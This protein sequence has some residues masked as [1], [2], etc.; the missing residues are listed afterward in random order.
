MIEKLNIDCYR[1]D[2]NFQPLEYWRNNDASDRRGITE[3]KHINGLYKL[4]D[5]L[6]DKFPNLLI[7]NCASGGRRIDIE[8]LRRSIPLWRSDLMCPANYDIEATQCHNLS[9]N[10][11]IPY[12]GTS[13]GRLYDE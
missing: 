5:A 1:Q 4:L 11:W 8:T 3:I 12:S 7:D 13:S 9:Y 6:L 10:M 2:F